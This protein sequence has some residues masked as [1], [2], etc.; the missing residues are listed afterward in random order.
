M[1]EVHNTQ[2]QGEILWHSQQWYSRAG[3][4]QSGTEDGGRQEPMIL[5]GTD[6][7]DWQ[8]FLSFCL[9]SFSSDLRLPSLSLMKLFL[10]DIKAEK[11]DNCS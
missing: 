5:I 11:G 10:R 2:Y 1:A 6:H 4:A 8:W 7:F 9:S 3:G